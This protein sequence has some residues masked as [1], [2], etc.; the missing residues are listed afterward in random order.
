MGVTVTDSLK[1]NC[2]NS[3]G[4]LNSYPIRIGY[5]SAYN[6]ETIYT[7]SVTPFC[8]KLMIQPILD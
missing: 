7:Y 1:Q 2:E 3:S 4:W 5:L 6:I 8:E